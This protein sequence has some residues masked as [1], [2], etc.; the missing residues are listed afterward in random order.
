MKAFGQRMLFIYGENDPWSTNAFEVS[1]R[2]DSY[3]FFTPAGNHGASILDLPDAEQT[4][5]LERLSVWA[6]V[7]MNAIAP[8]AGARSRRASGA[9]A[10]P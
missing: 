2:N 3:R 5:A 6:G 9:D 7:P 10:R 4:L 8:K 1:R